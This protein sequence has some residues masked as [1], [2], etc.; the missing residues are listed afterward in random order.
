MVGWLV[1]RPVFKMQ[2][3]QWNGDWPQM[4]WD[5]GDSLSLA[6]RSTE[7]ENRLVGVL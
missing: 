4:K 6:N 5:S 7:N 2:T 1:G 3:I